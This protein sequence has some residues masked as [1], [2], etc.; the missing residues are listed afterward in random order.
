MSVRRDRG[1]RWDGV[2][3]RSYKEESDAFRAVTRQVLAG[4]GDGLGWEIRYFEVAP[5]GWTTLERHR[6]PHAVVLIR[7]RGRVLVGG[8][9]HDVT[10]FDVVHVPPS[11]WHQLRAA[12]D[13]PLGFLCAVDAERDRPE[14]PAEADLAALRREPRIR[15]FIRA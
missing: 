14:R 7:G 2:P 9:I 13:E 15:E 8:E 1:F 6:H 12:E 10:P 3:V 4:P 5:G 11:T